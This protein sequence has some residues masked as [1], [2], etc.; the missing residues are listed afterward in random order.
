VHPA[1]WRMTGA[2][3][4]L[5]GISG[6]FQSAWGCAAILRG[7][8]SDTWDT[9]MAWAPS[10][11][12]S[13]NGAEIVFLALLLVCARRV[14]RD[15]PLPRGQMWSGIVT[16]LV[17]G[18]AYGRWEGVYTSA[19]HLTSV[20]LV[21]AGLFAGFA[22][23]LGIAM[24]T[25]AIDR[26]LLAALVCAALPL[27]LNAVWLAW[28]ARADSG[29][30]IPRPFD[31]QLYRLVI[32]WVMLLLVFHRWRLAREGAAVRGLAGVLGGGS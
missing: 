8:G 12:Y 6:L 11:N 1:T 21:D 30:W 10:L 16:G 14:H 32:D 13:R 5:M 20:A 28:L 29:A 24:I 27:P 23:V 9:Y 7:P 3:T 15:D 2:L 19:T 17:L 26:W 31:M 18:A 22:L 25:D 4:L